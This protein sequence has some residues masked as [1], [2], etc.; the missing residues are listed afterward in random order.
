MDLL[1]QNRLERQHRG[2]SNQQDLVFNIP[3]P[4]CKGRGWFA[5]DMMADSTVDCEQCRGTGD[6]KDA[7]T[8]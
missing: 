5:M 6:T 7:F 2:Y 3:C 1:E 8:P 4:H